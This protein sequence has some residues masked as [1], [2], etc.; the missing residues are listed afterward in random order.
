MELIALASLADRLRGAV[1]PNIKS[2]LKELK[3]VQIHSK[4]VQLG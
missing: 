2:S 3:V 4:V 1:S